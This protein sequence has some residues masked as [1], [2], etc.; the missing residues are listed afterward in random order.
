MILFLGGLLG[1][2]KEAWHFVKSAVKS[3]VESSVAYAQT[4]A[5]GLKVEKDTYLVSYDFYEQSVRDWQTI[6]QLNFDELVTSDLA[7][8]TTFD[9]REK[10]IL[11]ARIQ[12]TNTQTGESIDR[13]IT[14]END[15]ELTKGEWM[16]AAQGAVDDSIGSDPTDIDYI[17]E[18]EYYV[19]E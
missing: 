18:Y 17:A 19:K 14:V 16:N 7:I 4:I 11:Q 10:H 8:S 5:G 12:G 15:T 3:R 2:I 9:W 1:P 6:S 13:W